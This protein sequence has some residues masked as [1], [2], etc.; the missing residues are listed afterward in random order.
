VSDLFAPLPMAPPPEPNTLPVAIVV[1]NDEQ[2]AAYLAAGPVPGD[3]VVVKTAADLPAQ[4]G[5][6]AIVTT[7]DLGD[8]LR[9][10]LIRALGIS[11]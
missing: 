7:E 10:A 9:A 1:D 6:I 11:A 3:H 2:A 8:E 4:V 5:G